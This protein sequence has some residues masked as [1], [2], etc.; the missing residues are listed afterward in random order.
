M[1]LYEYINKILSNQEV[2]KKLAKEKAAHLTWDDEKEAEYKSIH[3]NISKRH[4]LENRT[5][6]YSNIGTYMILVNC[7]FKLEGTI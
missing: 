4:F 3:K 6:E 1:D 5:T 7:N 2:S